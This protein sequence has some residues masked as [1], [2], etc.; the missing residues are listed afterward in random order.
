MVIWQTVSIKN[1]KV[2]DNDPG[3]GKFTKKAIVFDIPLYGTN[4]LDDVKLFHAANVLAQS[5]DNIKVLNALKTNHGFL[6]LW[7]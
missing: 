7:C 1:I 4:E 5:I 6:L 3:Y 2:Y